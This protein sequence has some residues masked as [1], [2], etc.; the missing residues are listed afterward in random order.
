M[1]S[2]I[3]DKLSYINDSITNIT[4][5]AEKANLKSETADMMI[6]CASFLD[7]AEYP[8]TVEDDRVT[9]PDNVNHPSHYTARS[10]EC[11]D[12]MVAMFGEEAVI[13]FCKCNAWKYRYRA[14]LK[15]NAE[16][17]YQKSDWYI[18][19]ACELETGY[20]LF[21]GSKVC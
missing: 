1:E 5:Y 12:E 3:K 18:R 11:I 17:D 8:F 14:G 9:V 19:K 10:M 4:E 6:A 21:G 2:S 7:N 16:E 15:G 20:K 13:N